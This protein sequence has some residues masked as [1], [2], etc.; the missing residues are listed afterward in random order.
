[1]NSGENAVNSFF[2][3]VCFA[4]RE[5]IGLAIIAMLVIGANR[6]SAEEP[7]PSQDEA[8]T[9]AVENHPDILAAKAKLA[10]AESELN[11]KRIDV[12]R[13][14]LQAYGNLKNLEAQ[15]AAIKAKL[16]ATQHEFENANK[17]KVPGAV[18]AVELDRLRADVQVQQ[19]ALVQTML[20]REQTDKELRLL[21]GKTSATAPSAG[22]QSKAA[23]RQVPQ[24]PT[25]HQIKLVLMNERTSTDV[26]DQP[27]VEYLTFIYD[28]YHVPI[29]IH[30]DVPS[31]VQTGP[32]RINV[33]GV[34]LPAVFQA[35]E[36]FN[37]N[38]LQFVVRDYG[39]VLMNREQA[40][41]NGFM[42]LLDFVRESE[43]QAAGNRSPDDPRGD[44]N[45]NTARSATRKR[46]DAGDGNVF[47]D[48]K[49]TTKGAA[50][51]ANP[52][53]RK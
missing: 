52:F 28:K 16:D 46:A 20:Q 36:D 8:I 18:T 39:V 37:D 7:L 45:G 22:S 33:N 6:L 32:I 42:P 15:T 27:L 9:R 50:D 43:Q 3:K 10:L 30:P 4:T 34:P 19:A 21:I 38:R 40:E 2:S 11:G 47:G 44:A 49:P 5:L 31:D 12:S 24:G 29:Q 53:E 13:Q 35:I 41:K 25:V 48:S 51:S 23:P 26:S 14:V 17:A 1:M